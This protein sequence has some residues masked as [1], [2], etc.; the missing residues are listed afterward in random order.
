MGTAGV[1]GTAGWEG[2]AAAGV[3]TTLT[4]E[5]KRSASE[6]FSKSFE[7]TVREQDHPITS[8]ENSKN[9]LKEFSDSEKFPSAGN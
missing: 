3:A 8:Q 4:E 7:G 9:N 6:C 5:S 2:G 1:E